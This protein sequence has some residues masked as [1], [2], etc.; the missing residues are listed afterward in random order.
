MLTLI[1]DRRAGEPDLLADIL[2]GRLELKA[3]NGSTIMEV[4]SP[5]DGWTHEKLTET[6]GEVDNLLQSGADA[7]LNGYWIGSTEV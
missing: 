1:T 3:L 2:H 6:V 4:D 5:V 7:Y